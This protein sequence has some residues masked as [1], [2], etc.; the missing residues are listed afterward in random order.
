MSYSSWAKTPISTSYRWIYTKI[1]K[2]RK[3]YFL[4]TCLTTLTPGTQRRIMAQVVYRMKSAIPVSDKNTISVT[5]IIV[6]SFPVIQPIIITIWIII[7]NT[8]IFIVRVFREKWWLIV[9]DTRTGILQFRVRTRLLPSLQWTFFPRWVTIW[10]DSSL[11]AA[12]EGRQKRI[13]T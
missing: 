13:I 4:K 11:Q 10:D 12:S 3:G 5:P 1:Q 2:W 9:S 6:W 8:L 7:I